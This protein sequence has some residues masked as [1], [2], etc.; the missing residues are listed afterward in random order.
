MASPDRKDIL[1][2][3]LTPA[4]DG[5]WTETEGGHCRAV[6]ELANGPELGGKDPRAP[7]AL[8]SLLVRGPLRIGHTYSLADEDAPIY[9]EDRAIMP[10]SQ[11]YADLRCGSCVTKLNVQY[12][13]GQT[14]AILQ[15]KRGCRWLRRIARTY[16]GTVN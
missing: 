6:I 15:H 10:G 14:W 5:G 11:S 3:M 12:Q 4:G 9:I 16:S 8:A 2:M 7:Q 1:M 13:H